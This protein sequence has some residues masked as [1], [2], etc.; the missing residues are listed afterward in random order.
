M[1]GL[2]VDERRSFPDSIICI[3]LKGRKAFFHDV[4][5]LSF[6][7]CLLFTCSAGMQMPETG[8]AKI[9]AP[10]TG[11]HRPSCSRGAQQ[12]GTSCD[13]GAFLYD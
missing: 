4:F 9:T 8:F 5:E 11:G 1:V 10:I 2:V 7:V 12:P 6:R 13:G 3:M